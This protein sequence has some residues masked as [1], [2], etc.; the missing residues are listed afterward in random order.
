MAQA[1]VSLQPGL[2][3]V[4]ARDAV[5]CPAPARTSISAWKS[6]QPLARRAALPAS[7]QLSPSCA[8][9]RSGSTAASLPGRLGSRKPSST[10]SAGAERAPFGFGADSVNP[11]LILLFAATHWLR[12]SKA[13]QPW[14]CRLTAGG[15]LASTTL[16]PAESAWVRAGVPPARAVSGWSALDGAVQPLAAI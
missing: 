16:P 14:R 13:G 15:L 10:A 3:P 6:Q 5:R 7:G 11:P 12:Q 8:G 9:M 4:Q 1:G 2:V